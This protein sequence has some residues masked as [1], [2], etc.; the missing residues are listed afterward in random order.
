MAKPLDHWPR[1]RGVKS[2]IEEMIKAGNSVD[3]IV[4][5]LGVDRGTVRMVKRRMKEKIK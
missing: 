2:L 1:Q 3:D 5:E 4:L